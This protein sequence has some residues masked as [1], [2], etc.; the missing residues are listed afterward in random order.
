MRRGA[1]LR[2]LAKWDAEEA[3]PLGPTLKALLRDRPRYRDAAGILKNLGYTIEERGGQFKVLG[4]P[5]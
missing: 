1:V 2:E 5:E 4:D 3:R